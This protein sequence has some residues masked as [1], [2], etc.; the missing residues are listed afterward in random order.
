M[1]AHIFPMKE[2]IKHINEEERLEQA[3]LLY[4]N[5]DP[6]GKT[7]E[8]V[9]DPVNFS[10]PSG[11]REFWRLQFFNVE[12]YKLTMSKGINR[13]IL[14]DHNHF[15][16]QEQVGGYCANFAEIVQFD[17]DNYGIVIEHNSPL[18]TLSFTFKICKLSKRI[19]EGEEGQGEGIFI[20]RDL[21]TRELVDFYH[22]F[23]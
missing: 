5:F 18:G 4:F 23:D 21:H 14:L 8:W 7:F 12:N 6:I 16:T 9:G 1:N 13:T 2:I 10:L 19:L 20:Y 17:D 15:S 11:Q 3:L 22:P